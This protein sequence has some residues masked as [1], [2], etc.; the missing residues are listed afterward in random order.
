MT[1]EQTNQLLEKALVNLATNLL[2]PGK[3][4]AKSADAI[5]DEEFWQRAGIPGP[6]PTKRLNG[7]KT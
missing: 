1:E 5:S 6:V 3:E 7:G 4:K 2:G